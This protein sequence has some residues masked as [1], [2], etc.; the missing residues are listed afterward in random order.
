VL[1]QR[2][3]NTKWVGRDVEPRRRAH[4]APA[5]R[6]LGVRARAPP[7]ASS[8]RGRPQP[9]AVQLP[10]LPAPRDSPDSAPAPRAGAPRAPCRP[11]APSFDPAVRPRPPAL[12]HCTT[13]GHNAVVTIGRAVPL[14]K[15]SPLLLAPPDLTP[16]VSPRRRGRRRQAAALH[17][18]WATAHVSNFP[19]TRSTSPSHTLPPVRPPLVGARAAAAAAAGHRRAPTPATS[20]HQLRPPPNPR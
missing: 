16:A 11:D 20:P 8:A 13:A 14:F 1:K 5:H 2:V 17:R 4:A 9:Q 3:S 7:E 12:V 6:A 18:L 19:R 15:R 10:G